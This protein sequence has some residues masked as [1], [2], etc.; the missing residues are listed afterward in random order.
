MDQVEKQA[1]PSLQ[2]LPARPSLWYFLKNPPTYSKP[3]VTLVAVTFFLSALGTI[4]Y[5]TTIGKG[6]LSFSPPP[7]TTQQPA[8]P[9]FTLPTPTSTPDPTNWKTYKFIPNFEGESPF[10][11][12]YP[13]N[14]KIVEMRGINSWDGSGE[15]VVDDVINLTY[16]SYE[17]KLKF[18]KIYIKYFENRKKWDLENWIR[19]SNHA[20]LKACEEDKKVIKSK[21]NFLGF[22]SFEFKSESSEII[23]C[24]YANR[25]SFPVGQQR[26]IVFSKGQGIFNLITWSNNKNIDSELMQIL[27]TL[28]FSDQINYEDLFCHKEAGVGCPSGFKCKI[29]ENI[30][31]FNGKC[32]KEKD[33]IL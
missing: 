1:T 32:I 33:E 30:P 28:K 25:S 7:P 6:Q 18:G 10:S 12:K 21:N 16:I 2:N 31:E 14:Y 19:L 17:D 15:G 4:V 22:P 8:T 20:P 9:V 26:I 23:N 29:N 11:L 24:L 27:S 3:L 5:F 13:S